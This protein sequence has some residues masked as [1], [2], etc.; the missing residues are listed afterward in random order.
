MRG[1]VGYAHPFPSPQGW[2][3]PQSTSNFLLWPGRTGCLGLTELATESVG[4]SPWRLARREGL[5]GCSTLVKIAP[6]EEP[7]TTLGGGLWECCQEGSNPTVIAP[8]SDLSDRVALSEWLSLCTL[9]CPGRCLPLELFRMV[10]ICL[11][12]WG[13]LPPY[14]DGLFFLLVLASSGLYA[15]TLPSPS[16]T[17]GFI[18]NLSLQAG[19]RKASL[20]QLWA[21]LPP[22]P[23]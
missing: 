3:F 17:R 10:P 12:L 9:K 16:W 5:E 6:G 23:T 19:P 21:L 7:E 20:W 15:S 22:S 2:Y 1:N 18:F 8:D 11:F 13:S 4:V 14:C